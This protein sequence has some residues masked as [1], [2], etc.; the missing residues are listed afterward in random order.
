MPHT[1]TGIGPYK[2]YKYN[3]SSEELLSGN[4]DYAILERDQCFV[5]WSKTKEGPA[6]SDFPAASA[7]LRDMLVANGQRIRFTTYW[8]R[9]KGW[10]D[11]PHVG[12]CVK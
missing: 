10:H 12:A 9:A 2:T 1:R 5:A 11:S 6:R 7:D 4:L 8:T 3:P